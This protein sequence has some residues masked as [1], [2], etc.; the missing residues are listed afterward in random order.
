MIRMPATSGM[1]RPHFLGILTVA[2]VCMAAAGCMGSWA[3]RGTR[4]GYNKSV[5]YTASQ[6]ML[7][8]IVRMRYGETP[9]FL[10]MPSVVS[11]TEASMVGAGA[12]KSA[13][14]GALDGAFNL[15]DRPTI[16]YAPRTGED[17]GASMIKPLKAEAI[18][19]VSPG[20]DTRI[21]LLAFVDSIN[22]VRN[23]PQATS[24]ASRTL[25]DNEEYR[26]GVD[27]FI[28]LQNRGA[29]RMRV[30]ELDEKP[31]GSPLSAKH[32]IATDMLAAA[33]N[34][35][36]FQMTGDQA[37][38]LKRSRF[39]A[40]TVVPDAVDAADVHELARIFRLQPGRTAYRVKSQEDDEVDL[41][42]E[43]AAGD[44]PL[45]VEDVATPLAMA[46]GGAAELLPSPENPVVQ[47]VP[48]T[49]PGSMEP[50]DILS[51][52]VRSGYQV[53]AFLSK[54][55]DVPEPHVRRGVAPMFKALDGRPFNGHRLTR[56]LFHVC[57]QKHRPLRC[58]TAVYYR[59]YWFYIPDDDV[60]SRTTLN[61][62]KLVIDIRSESGDTPVLTLPVN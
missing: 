15:R 39:L 46:G 56:G 3:M 24:P 40:M 48:E 41:N 25:E 7:L 42:A 16:T 11:Q 22:G 12:Q 9:T 60:Q 17:M 1:R 33:E 36:V 19:D 61:Y 58:D 32:L 34:D 27:L 35:F 21:F 45:L 28:G 13:F 52:N 44:P 4:L 30:A 6:E 38:L 59:G 10:D 54:G 53:L 2:A 31:Q 57:V 43:S 37:V 55:V 8:N 20:D 18:L 26:D 29:V 14:Q 50:R 62:V 5:S 47:S 49:S 23:S 51:I